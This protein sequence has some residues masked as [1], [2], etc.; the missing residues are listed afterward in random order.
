LI[1][2]SGL[3]VL[4]S[5]VIIR[6]GTRILGLICTCCFVRRCAS[7]RRLICLICQS[8][9]IRL[10]LCCVSVIG[11]CSRRVLIPLI[12]L[13]LI[14][15]LIIGNVLWCKISSYILRIV[16]DLSLCC[17]INCRILSQVC[18]TI[19]RSIKSLI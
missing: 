4:R 15:S 13:R 3:G 9:W 8:W 2:W 17:V 14:N 18:T 19:L 12:T 7:L 16:L 10:C 6:Y 5:L 11:I 1:W